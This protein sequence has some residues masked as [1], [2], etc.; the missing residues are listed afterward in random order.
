[1]KKKIMNIILCFAILMQFI[2]PSFIVFADN[3]DL[4][5]EQTETKTLEETTLGGNV[6]AKGTLEIDLKFV[7]PIRN[8][9]NSYMNLSIVDAN[10]KEL[11]INLSD[12]TSEVTSSPTLGDNQVELSVRKLDEYG[13]L[14][15]G[16]DNEETIMYY[17]ITVYHLP[18]G[19]YTIK[20]TGN[21]YKTYSAKVTLD[22]YS[23]RISLSNEA[24]MFEAG[25][26]N[27]DGKVD[28]SDIDTLLKYMGTSN[29]SYDLNRDGKVDIADLNYI[30]AIINGKDTK[31]KVV[32]TTAILEA[33]DITVTGV[34]SN[35]AALEDILTDDGSIKIIP[36]NGETIS[37]TN[38]AEIV[39]DMKK[40]VETSEIRLETGMDNVPEKMLITV[41]D[42][43]GKKYNFTKN[44]SLSKDISNFTDKANANTIVIDLGGQVAIKKVTIKVIETSGD[45]LA[46][47]AKV[48]FLNNVYEEVP[49][50]K[51]EKP[52]NVKATTKS[53]GMT[54]TYDHMSNITGY[55]I[56]VKTMSGDQVTKNDIYQTTYETFDISGLKNYTKYN[57]CVQAVNQEWKSPCSDEITVIPEP[58]RL[59][60]KVDMVTLTPV[61][62]GFN[63]GWKKMDDTQTYNIYYREKGTTE[64]KKIADIAGSSYQLRDLKANTT[65]ELAVSGNNHK[66][67]GTKSAIVVGTTKDY[68]MPDT[69]NFGL[70]NTPNGTEVTEHIKSVTLK[71]G[72]NTPND[73]SYA[74]VDNDY[75]SYFLANTWDI[76]GFN[77]GKNGPI[78][79]FDDY[80]TIDYIFIVPKEDNAGFGYAKV[81]YWDESGKQQSVSTYSGTYST[82]SVTALRSPNGQR[83][84]KIQLSKPIKTNKIQICLANGSASG[85]IGIRELRFYERDT[86]LDDVAALFKDDLRV[87]LQ[88]NV[89]EEMIAELEKRAN[90][91]DE[92]SGEYNPNQKVIL[93]DLEYARKILNDTAIQDVIVVDQSISNSKNSHLGFGM[94]ISD[95]QPLGVV[96]RPGEKLTIYVG[97]KGNV[98][99]Q[100]VFTQYY[101]EANVWNQTVTNLK[102][103]QNII[104][105]PTLGS[106]ST[107]RGGSV[108]IRYPNSKESS[109]IKVRVSG[110][111]KIPVLDLHSLNTE[112]EKKAAIEKYVKEIESYTSNLKDTYAEQGIEYNERTSVLNATEIVTSYGLFSVSATAIKN[113]IA[114]GLTTT[115]SKV[116]RVYEST[117]AFDEMM[118][119]FY[120]H[121]GLSK[122]AKDSKDELPAARVNIR[123]MRM[124]DGAFMYAGGLHIGIEYGSIGALVQGKSFKNSGFNGY[125][126]WGISH[127]IGHQI[128]QGNIAYA[129]VT[130]NVYA[131]LAQTA[132]DTSK[133][134]LEAS[135]IYPKIYEKVTSNTIGKAGNVFVSL[136]MYWQ[137]HLAYDDNKTFEDT[138]SIYARINHL[139]RTKS[140][141]GVSKDELL[142]MYASEAAGKN[143]VPFFEKWGFV[144]GDTARE[145]AEQYPEEERAIWFLNDSAR[146]YRM[147]GGTAMANDT[148][149]TATLT[150]ADSQN[151]RFTLNFNVNKDS[152]SIL[153]YEI[154]RNG[155]SI[156]FTTNN[157]FTD[158]IGALNNRALTYEVIAYDYLLNKTDSYVLEE[159]KVSHDG[160]IKKDNFTIE[161]NVKAA[162]DMIDHENEEM[163]ETKLSV[164]NLIDG[165]SSTYFH[166]TEKVSNMIFSDNLLQS[167]TDKGSANVVINL[168]SK[169]AIAGIKYQAALEDGNLMK[170]TISKYEIYVS[171]DATNW[172]LAKSGTFHLT[173]ENNYTET[174]YFDKEGSTG[175]NQLW[176][177]DNI[178]Y[179][180][181]VSVGNFNGLSGAEID[182][183]APPGDNVELSSETV[184]V[185]KEDFVYDPNQ[186]PIKAGSV[187]FKGNYRGNPAFNVMLLVDAK[188]DK[189]IYSGENF[190]FAKLPENAPLD[191][192]ADGIFFYV[193]SKEDYEKMTGTS[194]RARLYR[195][196]DAETNEG[197]RITSTSLSV[198]NLPSYDKLPEMEIVDTT[199]GTK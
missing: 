32:D 16:H 46:E 11:K 8:T 135:N 82:E 132:N 65:Y 71:T 79:E 50:P 91:K 158:Q 80:Y 87:E 101:A 23:K 121:K 122:N 139:S 34:F 152:D 33:K 89:T 2:M 6:D 15:L 109:E 83:Y 93:A 40:S 161:S 195:V 176:T 174:V 61:Y 141:A 188:D 129:E 168:N 123:Y 96:A 60:P 170:D 47:I 30:T 9:N 189:I 43:N 156:M 114:S 117:S 165:N 63:I 177:Y 39:F 29:S 199:K 173:K 162:T 18:K 179:V 103:G 14:L 53:E 131:L 106:M 182:V 70:I 21:G 28:T 31:A 110:G 81:Y 125:F 75:E 105:V 27:G 191:E 38:P 144:I 5:A 185:L 159:V 57:V 102:K 44:F 111:T 20:L 138:N 163:D 67:E 78:V 100:I 146:R 116:N 19:T 35:D 193:V 88:D 181:I 22:S 128:N 183:I 25:D 12:K 24:G 48:E 124:F 142:V 95:Y 99:P 186:E 166:G 187:V 4:G 7:L 54:I 154:R 194:V 66:G 56:I 133:S 107:E 160:S 69:Y 172:T 68:I 184:G 115:D 58:N 198:T 113:A 37:L 196:N 155:E 197:Q 26:V 51:I 120:R 42:E 3:V 190:L 36:K 153:G 74:L 157:T 108:Y 13:K 17:G 72:T 112:A 178:S 119:L 62:A 55:E 126:G 77:F 84:F 137:L 94:P 118:E 149:V 92:K 73:N 45:N 171:T 52:T 175:G 104:D 1:M 136:G 98:M 49:E 192:I 10:G 90:A 150:E 167:I 151:K 76:G 86:L 169:M 64:F 59:P 134:R 143:L 41:E 148:K 130:N 180:K 127:E 164:R 85:S 145:F 147:N 97:T 140:H